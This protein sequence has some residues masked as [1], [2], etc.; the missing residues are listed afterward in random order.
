MWNRSYAVAVVMRS[1]EV[2]QLKVI[3]LDYS[4][5]NYSGF[6]QIVNS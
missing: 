6:T 4:R 3:N 5:L 1:V 2:E